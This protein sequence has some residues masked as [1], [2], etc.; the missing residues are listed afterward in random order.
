MALSCPTVFLSELI[1]R[2]NLSRTP[3]SRLPVVATRFPPTTNISG[4][5]EITDLRP[6]TY[7]LRA[8]VLG[9]SVAYE[10]FHVSSSPSRKAL[11]KLHFSWGDDA[12]AVKAIVGRITDTQIVK[13]GNAL[14]NVLHSD[15]IPVK[16]V[17]LTLLAPVY[18][19]A[20]TAESDDAGN[21]TIKDVPAETYVLHVEGGTAGDRLFDSADLLVQLSHD[22]RRSKIPIKRTD[23]RGGSCGGTSLEL[24]D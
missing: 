7:W 21:F 8:D 12:P 23:A 15:D 14:W 1:L 6:G 4:L 10:C 18:G 5:A 11:H 20:Y 16:N 3:Q 24:Q 13:T 17:K 9:T 19:T 2:V 22:A